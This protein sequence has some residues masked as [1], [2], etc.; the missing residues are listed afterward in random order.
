MMRQSHHERGPVMQAGHACGVRCPHQVLVSPPLLT[1]GACQI[2]GLWCCVQASEPMLW[3]ALALT[4]C[5][6]TSFDGF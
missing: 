4:E 2:L 5:S 3:P 1:Y 6:E